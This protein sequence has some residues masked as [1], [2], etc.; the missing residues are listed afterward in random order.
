MRAIPPDIGV[1]HF[2]GIGGIGMSGIAEVLHDLN[3]KVQGSDISESANVKRLQD[4]GISVFIGQNESNI[5]GASVVV[6]S[7]A[8]KSDNPE[9]VAA[10]DAGLPIIRR[11]E[12]LAELMHL[13]M[14][15]SIGGTH[16]K[17]TTTS[18]VGA[19]LEEGG[20]DPT[21]INGGV[22]NNYGTNVRLG[23]GDWVVV[24]ADESDGTF[25]RLPSVVS[26]VTNIDPEHLDHYGDFESVCKAFTQFVRN[27]PFYGYGVVCSDHPGVQ[28]ILPDLVGRKV[29]TYGTNPQ[30]HVQLQNIRAAQGGQIF[31]VKIADKDIKDI[32]LPMFGEHNALN[33]CA[34]IAIANEMDVPV[35]LIKS[36]LE[37][38]SGVK[39]RFTNTGEVNGITIIDDY[40]HHPVEIR[41]VLKAARQAVSENGGNVIAIMQPHRY[42]RLNDLFDDFATCFQDADS[43]F[44]ADVY[45]A[46]E[47]PIDGANKGALTEAVSKHGHKDVVALSSADNLATLI[48][49]KAQDGDYVIFLGAGDI[50]KWAYDL[51]KALENEY[52][53]RKQKRA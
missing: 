20:F 30:A 17:T 22:V 37:K 7:S 38:F 41:A 15:I 49:D 35:A 21:V 48:A 6:T 34:A 44:I 32:F 14:S 29:I 13:K 9:L 52:E 23:Q 47:Q 19:M 4:K 31:D 50:T 39:R 18:L 40:G 8:I 5:E 10:Q 12:M 51:P 24:E 26:V 33:A 16:G 3:Y 1:F 46:G 36:A 45:E 25:T 27:I 28:K 53:G 2:I 11:A 42:S 43:V